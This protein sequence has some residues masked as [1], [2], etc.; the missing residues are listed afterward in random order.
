MQHFSI[1]K[2]AQ[3]AGVS[4]RTLR[5][6]DSIGLLTALRR[7]NNYRYYGTHEVL[8]LQQILFYKKLGLS[9]DEILN[10]FNQP[11]Y[12]LIKTLKAHRQELLTKQKQ[13][14]NLLETVE[15]T[16]HYLEGNTPMNTRKI[17][18][19][20]TPDK[21]E[22]HYQE[23]QKRWDPKLLKSSHKCWKDYGKTRQQEI[24]A[25]GDMIYQSLVQ[26]VDKDVEAAEVQ[27]LLSQW[28]QHLKYFYEPTLEM[29]KGLGDLYV[30]CLLYTSPSPRD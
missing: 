4:T 17:F 25:E 27:E 24:M 20:F 7:D 3:I 16:L 21:E 30:D 29:L 11:D 18:K 14:Q 5:H 28:H 19:G 1:K 10:V 12:T 23:A 8:R 9:L 22:Q 26:H 15:H 6:Y 2:L 13:F